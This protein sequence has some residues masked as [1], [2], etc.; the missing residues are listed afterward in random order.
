MSCVCVFQSKNEASNLF[1]LCFFFFFNSYKTIR[2]FVISRRNEKLERL[3]TPSVC[4]VCELIKTEGSKNK[5]K[6]KKG[7]R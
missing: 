1:T 4:Y 2:L 3:L 5:R 6:K 7:V